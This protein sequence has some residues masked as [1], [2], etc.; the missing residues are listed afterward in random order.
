MVG[1][2]KIN[3]PALPGQHITGSLNYYTFRTLLNITPDGMVADV[4]AGTG[5][6]G[7]PSY[8]TDPTQSLFDAVVRAI[9]LRAQ[10]VIVGAVFTTTET[11]PADLPAA[12]GQGASTVY[13]MHVMIDHDQAWVI[14]SG[15]N[16]DLPTTLNGTFGFVYTSPT[17]NNN[18]SFT[19]NTF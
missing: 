6:A 7:V 12:N 18:V 13:N 17:T 5:A 19:L 2:Q 1:F 4:V 15:N 14:T 8:V 3:G 9:S 11:N 10:P 16:P